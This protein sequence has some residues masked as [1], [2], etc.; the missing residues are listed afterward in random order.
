MIQLSIIIVTYNSLQ[1]IFNC[2]ESIYEFNDLEEGEFEIIIVDNSSSENF[3]EM[4]RLLFDKYKNK[5]HLIRNK[6]N[7]GF[8][9]GNNVGIKIA[10]GKYICLANPDILFRVPVFKKVLKLFNER[11][12]LAMIGGKQIGGRNSSFLNRPEYDFFVFTATLSDFLNRINLY[13]QNYFYLSGAL[14]FIDKEKFIEIG[15]FDENMFLYFEESD[16]TKRFLRKS[17]STMFVKEFTYD[18]L[19]GDRGITNTSVFDIEIDS[20]KKYCLKYHYNFKSFVNRKIISYRIMIFCYIFLG[21]N[22][23]VKRSRI[24]LNRFLKLKNEIIFK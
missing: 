11:K 8:G 17:Y 19:I 24:Y 21:K 16:I 22:D 18:H 12:Y 10:K 23:K 13:F 20:V 1:Y 4:S 5:I 15:L 7:K 6:E 9:Q 14:L 3:S 2:I